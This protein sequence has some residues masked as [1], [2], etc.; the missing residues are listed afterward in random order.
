M[1]ELDEAADFLLRKLS[2]FQGALIVGMVQPTTKLKT[3]QVTTVRARETRMHM[4]L[5]NCKFAETGTVR[6]AECASSCAGLKAKGDGMFG[7][8]RKLGSSGIFDLPNSLFGRQT[9]RT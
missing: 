6:R 5:V 8:S 7:R 3:V 4:V 2:F 9:G 1:A